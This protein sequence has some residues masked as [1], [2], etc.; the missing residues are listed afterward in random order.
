MG[1]GGRVVIDIPPIPLTE[2]LLVLIA[3]LLWRACHLLSDIA[4]SNNRLAERSKQLAESPPA[5]PL[6]LRSLVPTPERVMRPIMVS[7]EAFEKCLL[8]DGDVQVGLTPSP[9]HPE[10]GPG[11][12][13]TAPP[14]P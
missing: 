1:V 5:P 9:E 7:A 6:P 14:G 2:A 8:D 4:R 10:P 3:A 13:A 11:L 12:T